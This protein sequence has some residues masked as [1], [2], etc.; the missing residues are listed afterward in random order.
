MAVIKRCEKEVPG[1]MTEKQEQGRKWLAHFVPHY[2]GRCTDGSGCPA[3]HSTQHSE[4]GEIKRYMSETDERD[5]GRI[6]Q[7]QALITQMQANVHRFIH[8]YNTCAVERGHSERTVLTDKRIEYWKNWLGRCKVVEL[9]HNFGRHRTGELLYQELG[10]T[11]A[12]EVWK[13]VAKIDRDKTKHRQIKSAPTYNSRKKTLEYEHA[14]RKKV[15]QDRAAEEKKLHTYSLKMQL[16]Y[17]RENTETAYVPMVIGGKEEASAVSEAMT[18]ENKKRDR[19]KKR[20]ADV[21]VDKENCMPVAVRMRIEGENKSVA[22]TSAA[23][24]SPP[25]KRQILIVINR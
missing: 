23:N 3:T 12:D 21:M 19:P 14:A 7:L 22:Q 15:V 20:A 25:S 18:G 16:L 9:L 4:G 1:T 8:G 17:D 13:E 5:K 6:T 24:V 2:C 11:V 10:W